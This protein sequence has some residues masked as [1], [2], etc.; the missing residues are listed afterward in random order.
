MKKSLVLLVSLFL[1]TW[2]TA[3]IQT[4]AASPAGKVEQKIGLTDCTIEYARPGMKGRKV[5]GELVPYGETWRTGANAATKLTFSDDI[6]IGGKELKKGSYALLTKP[7][8]KSWEVMLYPHT[9]S[10]YGTYLESK[11]TPVSFMVTPTKL[12]GE[13]VESFTMGFSD[14]SN[15][16]G[17]LY[18]VW[19]NTRVAIP[20]KVNTD[21]AVEA[22]IAK[23][24][25][26][27]SAGDYYSAANYYFTEKKDLNKAL[28]WINKSISMGN[29]RYWVLRT[30]SLIQADLG[31][32]KGAI[33]TATKSL[34]MAKADDVGHYV[35]MNEASIAEWK[36][37]K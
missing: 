22:S 35:R 2:M 15:H 24:M 16:G 34:E 21:K 25:G 13:P 36:K 28:E 20:I 33:E 12:S 37:K 8:E 29:E 18:L 10:N 26:G 4:P 19:E 9:S 31:D 11:E 3:Q 5:F 17:N 27:P 7:G 30:K 32:T 23:V 14:L 6:M 1:A